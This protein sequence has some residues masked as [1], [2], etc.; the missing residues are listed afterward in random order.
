MFYM[1]QYTIHHILLHYQTR[2]WIKM[3]KD[4]Q[5]CVFVFL[6]A[7]GRKASCRHSRRPDD[8]SKCYIQPVTVAVTWNQYTHSTRSLCGYSSLSVHLTRLKYNA[9]P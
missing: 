7:S 3:D 5:Q 1:L 4:R 8:H 2:P 6:T 9:G